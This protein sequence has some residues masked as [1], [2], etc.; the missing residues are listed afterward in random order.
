MELPLV[1]FTGGTGWAE[2][3]DCCLSVFS[4]LTERSDPKQS[5]TES[6]GIIWITILC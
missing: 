6:R 2:L 5:L 3:C 1:S 4:K